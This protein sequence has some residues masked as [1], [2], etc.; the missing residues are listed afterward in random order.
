MKLK[1]MLMAGVLAIFCLT[2]ASAKTYDISFASAAKVGNIQLKAGDYRMSVN[3]TKA[4]F[5]DVSTLKTYTTEIKVEN[6][7]KKFDETKVNTSSD[8]GTP[9]VKDIEL[10]GSKMKV[11]F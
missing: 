7:D 11:D 5:T 9:V 2:L 8:G 1:S 4:T 3:G 10:G 6:S